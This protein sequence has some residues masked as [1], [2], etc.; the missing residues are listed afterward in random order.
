MSS[1]IKQFLGFAKESQKKQKSIK[2]KSFTSNI[3]RFNNLIHKQY[4]NIPFESDEI[5]EYDA[6]QTIIQNKKMKFVFHMNKMEK[7][8]RRDSFQYTKDEY[9]ELAKTF[10]Q[11]AEYAR[12]RSEP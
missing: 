9:K 2:R 4:N 8:L 1:V 6:L 7:C 10:E 11:L 5:V 3:I 12:Y